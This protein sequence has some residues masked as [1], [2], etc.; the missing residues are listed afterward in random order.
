MV[1]ARLGGLFEH[2]L[3]LLLR[4]AVQL[5]LESRLQLGV[6]VEGAELLRARDLLL[7]GRVQLVLQHLCYV[8]SRHLRMR[9]C[10]LRKFAVAGCLGELL[11]LAR[12]DAA[13][14]IGHLRL[15]RLVQLVLQQVLCARAHP[16]LGSA[17]AR[18][19]SL[20]LSWPFALHNSVLGLQLGDQLGVGVMRM[21]DSDS[22]MPELSLPLVRLLIQLRL[23]GLLR[24]PDLLLLPLL[25]QLLR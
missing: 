3:L 11:L 22:L 8:A 13:E 9:L 25:L 20:L 7:H 10:C 6:T 21:D 2:L 14:A 18:L 24:L 19:L 15:E 16:L 5:R 12:L 17:S 1:H 23:H 4:L